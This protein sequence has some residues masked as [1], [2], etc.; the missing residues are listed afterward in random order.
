MNI[1]I[2]EFPSKRIF[3]MSN[4]LILFSYSNICIITSQA[5]S[6]FYFMNYVPN[7]AYIIMYLIFFLQ[8]N[9]IYSKQ[10][11]QCTSRLYFYIYW[12][13]KTS[14]C[15]HTFNGWLCSL[16]FLSACLCGNLSLASGKCRGVFILLLLLLVWVFLCVYVC[17][18][19]EY[20]NTNNNEFSTF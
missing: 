4:N 19:I 7:C 6:G 13:S 3:E 5:R 15:R 18:F 8:R 16:P 17:V 10:E 2:D 12:Y 1:W 11:V 9:D 14:P 20:R